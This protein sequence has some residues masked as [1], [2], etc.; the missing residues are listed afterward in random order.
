M[1]H[2][3]HV[4]RQLPLAL[5]SPLLALLAWLTLSIT[6][7]VWAVAGR[8]RR[9]ADTLP[10]TGAA[11]VVI[12]N[13]NGRDLLEKYLPSVVE[14]LAGNPRNEVI[15]VE[16]GS[17]DGSAEFV[18]ERFPEVRLLALEKNLGFGGG[19]TYGFRQARNDIVVLLNSDM[20][21]DPGFLQP[22][23][24][25]FAD[26]KVFAVACQIFFSDPNRPREETG[27]TQAWWAQGALRVRHREDPAIT[28]LYPCF[29]GGG[30]SCAFDRRKLL[31]LGGFDEM[32]RP[33]YLEDT[34]LGYLAWKR[35][36]KV[37]YQPASRVWHEH[38]GTIGR[39]FSRAYID[40]VIQKNRLLFAWKNIHDLRRF[41]AHFAYTLANALLSLAIG[42]SA[43]RASLAGLGR[44]FLQLPAAMRARWRARSLAVVDDREAFR[45][46]LGG[47][48]L[49]RFTTRPASPERLSVLF[50]SPY[51]VCPPIHGGGVFMNQ[52]LRELGR[53]ADVHLLA[54]LDA[55]GEADAHEELRPFC[56]SMEFVVRLEGQPKRAGSILPYSVRE[57]T[58][59]GL[60]WI[61]H[62]ILYS[63]QVDILQL[64]YTNMGQYGGVYRQL[65][66]VLFEHD[67]YFQ[68]IGRG[69]RRARPGLATA[70]AFVEYLRALRYELRLLPAMDRIQTCSA[71]NKRYLLG[72]LPALR[73]RIDDHVRAGID[74]ARYDFRPSGREPFTILFLGSFRHLPNLEALHWFLGR[75]MPEILRQEP[76]ARLL[77]A[78]SDPPA[79][80]T[81]PNF[82]GAVQLLGFVDD[83]REAL[84]RYT[85]FVCPILTGSG[86][87][88]KLLEAFAAGIPVVSTRLGAEG[89]SEVDGEI[90]ALADS[91]AD[92]AAHVVELLDDSQRAEA[93][94]RAARDYVVAHRDM[95]AITRELERTYRGALTSKR[96]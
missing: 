6:D 4:V 86:V 72:F 33:F 37:L 67:V 57:F 16:N 17:T 52:T 14:A 5:V 34:D 81:I 42:E 44:A 18:R 90:C 32:L 76:R 89:L 2:F 19:S 87:R 8:R 25:G 70:K 26:E 47:Y 36:W 84:A 35:G 62:R 27:L 7:L 66:C 88:V 68:S 41:A 48:F 63:R 24:D 78:G 96:P 40:S 61:I 23:L 9:P 71:E 11:S 49:D 13:W 1:A 94:A 38:R 51:P 56:A 58:N 39:N 22:L 69:L 43:E 79:D 53:L 28:G 12:P 46:P 55:P 95:A 92:F 85:V 77:I 83:V 74:T 50:V 15:V 60:E 20:R 82:D 31:E 54:L 30:G 91:P 93:L 80:Y 29:Y 73:D 21:V 64:E 65:A 59:D 45:R 3:F 10:D 75:V